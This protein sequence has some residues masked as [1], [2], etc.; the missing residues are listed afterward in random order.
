M[1]WVLFYKTCLY[2]TL[3]F[4][5]YYLKHFCYLIILSY[6]HDPV[7]YKFQ[8]SKGLP[9]WLSGK[10]ST[11][12]CRRCR[13]N[14]KF[15]KIPWEGNGD[16]LPVFLL[17]KFCGQRS[18]VG[19]SPRGSKESDMTER[20]NIF[21]EAEWNFHHIFHCYPRELLKVE[22]YLHF[23]VKE[24]WIIIDDEHCFIMNTI[25]NVFKCFT[26]YFYWYDSQFFPIYSLKIN[27]ETT[28]RLGENIWKSCYWQGINF[29]NIQTAYIA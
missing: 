20:L 9:W 2:L 12:Q 4:K 19:Y 8:Y 10:K 23:S 17:G 18:L 6:K 28:Y 1:K 21:W 24:K 25:I 13:F 16:L 29:Q 15:G 26:T 5:K 7:I 27:I 11:C 3:S 14:P 22:N